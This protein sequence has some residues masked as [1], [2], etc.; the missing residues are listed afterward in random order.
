ME[1]GPRR[2]TGAEMETE[3]KC[4]QEKS[5]DGDVDEAETEQTKIRKRQRGNGERE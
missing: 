2:C 4:I 1:M 5:R 3:L